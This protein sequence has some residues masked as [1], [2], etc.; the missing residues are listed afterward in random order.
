MAK[1]HRED[2]LFLALSTLVFLGMCA[3]TALGMIRVIHWTI[4]NCGDAPGCSAADGLISYWWALFVPAVLLVAYA[5]NRV[6][7]ARLVN[8]KA[9][10]T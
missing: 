1:I 3:L 6:Y 9:R 2:L 5:F 4:G 8:R 7:Q 10:Q